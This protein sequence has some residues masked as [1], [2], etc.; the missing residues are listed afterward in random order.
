MSLLIYSGLLYLLGI[1]IILTFKPEV[2]FTKEG[3]WK[4]FGLGRSKA[5]YTWMP[6]WLFAILWAILSY[7]FVLIIASHTGLAG[8]TENTEIN[9]SKDTIEPENVSMKAM[10]PVPQNV[11]KKK[12]NSMGDMKKGYYILDTNETMKKGIPKYIYLGPEAPNLVY[13][14]QSEGDNTVESD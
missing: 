8:V 10:S 4:E 6:F 5:R 2:M 11:P 3:N 12:P 1:S 14:H 9:I 7:L 13:H